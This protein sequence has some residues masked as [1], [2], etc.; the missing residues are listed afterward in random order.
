MKLTTYLPSKQ[1]NQIVLSYVNS[2]NFSKSNFNEVINVHEEQPEFSM[3][4][5][6]LQFI[7]VSEVV[8]TTL[9]GYFLLSHHLS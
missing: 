8:V 4:L 6:I 9:T 7:V 2:I 1:A 3:S 5:L